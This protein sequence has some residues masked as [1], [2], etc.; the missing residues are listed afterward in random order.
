[1][2]GPN[3]TQAGIPGHA[4]QIQERQD[5]LQRALDAYGDNGCGPGGSAYADAQ[6]Y[7]DRAIPTQADWEAVNGRP[8]PAGFSGPTWTEVGLVALAVG[9]TLF[10][11]DG[12]VG[13]TFTWGMV[14]KV[15]AKRALQ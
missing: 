1:M 14:A 9:G 5:G 10:P 8:M 11:F 4:T 12:P 2:L 3:A 15:G 6:S 7:V 13:D